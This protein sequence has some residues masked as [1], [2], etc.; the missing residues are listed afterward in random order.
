MAATR[1]PTLAPSERPSCLGGETAWGETRIRDGWCGHGMRP[2]A[3]KI[4]RTTVS[5]HQDVR[6]A[7][8]RGSLVPSG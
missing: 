6:V 8:R 2:S 3:G 1:R 4:G 5:D 7:L